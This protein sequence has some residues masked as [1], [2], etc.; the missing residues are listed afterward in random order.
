MVEYFEP[1]LAYLEKENQGR[2]VAWNQSF[3]IL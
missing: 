1:L 2:D 3:C